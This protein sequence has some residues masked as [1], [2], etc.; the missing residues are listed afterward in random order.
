MLP[1]VLDG[2]VAMIFYTSGSTGL[3]KGVVLSHRNLVA[4]AT[5][6]VSYLGNHADDT[7]LAVLPLSFDAGF[8]QLTHGVSGGRAWCC[9]T[10]C[11][12]AM[13]CRPW[14]ASA[15]PA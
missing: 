13:C 1:R 10:T 4:G 9:S 7:L 2:D 8:S 3:P 5:S 15:S 11:C 6:V 12:R 14:R